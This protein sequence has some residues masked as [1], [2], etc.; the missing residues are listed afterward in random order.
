MLQHRAVLLHHQYPPAD[1]VD[2]T[3]H[4]IAEGQAV[5]GVEQIPLEVVSPNELKCLKA[6]G[7][8]VAVQDAFQKIEF[9]PP[10]ELQALRQVE[11]KALVQHEAEKIELVSPEEAQGL[12]MA[13]I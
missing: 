5:R 10:E 11:I 12:K 8:S 2:P 3:T 6:A 4:R 1:L 7:R 13:E 9:V